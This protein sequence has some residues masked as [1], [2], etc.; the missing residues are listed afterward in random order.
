MIG[1]FE[2]FPYT[3]LHRLNLD[4]LLKTVK[5]HE[6]LYEKLV[7]LPQF[8][9]ELARLWVEIQ[10]VSYESTAYTDMKV[11]DAIINMR[12]YTNMAVE[13]VR[14]ELMQYMMTAISDFS[15]RLVELNNLFDYRF[16]WLRNWLDLQL[17]IIKNELI[18]IPM[19]AVF[20]PLTGTY[21]SIEKVFA[22]FFEYMRYSAITARDFDI[23]G[24]DAATL[25]AIMR[26]GSS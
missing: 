25:D 6:E 3:D 9:E 8:A 16:D 5:K 22:S 13:N 21:Q 14:L 15:S 17:E 11:G 18:N 24:L 10:R 20:N 26:S 1:A 7:V 23:L 2:N 4:W 12:Q 19:P